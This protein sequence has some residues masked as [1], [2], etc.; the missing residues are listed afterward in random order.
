MQQTEVTVPQFKRFVQA[1]GY[2]TEAEKSGGCW[3]TGNGNRW[4]QKQGTSWKKPG[5]GP[6]DNDLPVVCIAWNDATAFA[7]W[8]SKRERRTY[9]LPTEAK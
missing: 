6:L 4:R 7:R 1:T 3:I 9:R 5:R 2:K 8:L